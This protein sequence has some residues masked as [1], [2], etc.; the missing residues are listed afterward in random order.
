[1]LKYLRFV[2]ICNCSSFKPEMLQ[3]QSHEMKIIQLLLS[4][5]VQA[6]DSGG[7]SRTKAIQLFVS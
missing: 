4:S 1:M 3:K 6:C 2:E 5:D 7:K